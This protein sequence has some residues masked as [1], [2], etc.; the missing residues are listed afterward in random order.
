M[1][2]SGTKTLG[3][4]SCCCVWL[5]PG[6]V[7]GLSGK[8]GQCVPA[9]LCVQEGKGRRGER[10]EGLTPVLPTLSIHIPIPSP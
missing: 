1:S 8:E 7:R 3:D 9:A 10:R 6:D 4:T 2:G 5:R